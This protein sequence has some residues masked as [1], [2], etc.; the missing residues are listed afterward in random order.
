MSFCFWASFIA[1]FQVLLQLNI[2]LV[3]LWNMVSLFYIGSFE[4]FLYPTNDTATTFTLKANISIFLKFNDLLLPIAITQMN[5]YLK[6]AMVMLGGVWS[7]S[8]LTRKTPERQWNHS[9]VFILVSWFPIWFWCLCCWIQA[10][11]CS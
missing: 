6:S 8:E 1:I 9:G 2:L 7:C 3:F 4:P 11:K 5:I 10:S